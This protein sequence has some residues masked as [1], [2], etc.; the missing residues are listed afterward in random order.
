MDPVFFS[1]LLGTLAGGVFSVAAAA[2][3]SLTTL[4]RWAPR[5]VSFSVG[6]LLAA[7]FLDILPQAAQQLPFHEV[8]V[9]VLVGI[10]AFFVLEKTALWR[11]DHACQRATAV[12]PPAGVMIVLGDG[13]HNF[14]DGMLIAAAFLQDPSLGIATAIAVITHEI[15][16]EL[17]DFM[18]LLAAGYSRQRALLFN[19]IS[20]L[21][22]V[23]GGLLGY[24]VLQSV[25]GAIPYLLALAAASFIYIAVA[26]LMP[27]L[28]R[29]RTPADFA[30]QFALLG[31][32]AGLVAWGG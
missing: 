6:V 31:G 13:L 27:A 24:L 25:Q 16:Q 17:G 9:T 10:C 3:L 20:G 22:A 30:V 7:A 5:M 12:P 21:A 32:G 14:V 2:L 11:H 18:V 8:G 28:Q 4:A 15:P 19:V 1:I 29:H 23:A 26:D